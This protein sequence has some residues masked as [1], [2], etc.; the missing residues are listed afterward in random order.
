[1]YRFFYTLLGVLDCIF[2]FIIHPIKSI[3]EYFHTMRFRFNIEKAFIYS[4]ALLDLELYEPSIYDT[5]KITEKIQE[6]T[7]NGNWD[8]TLTKK[9]MDFVNFMVLNQKADGKILGP[10]E[11]LEKFVSDS[12]LVVH[13]PFHDI[14][15]I[16]VCG[17]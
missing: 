3:R 7:G 8:R 5:D 17:R 13:Y 4:T 1:M 11:K 15:R 14:F 10:K 16:L 12:S 9:T 6:M 2:L